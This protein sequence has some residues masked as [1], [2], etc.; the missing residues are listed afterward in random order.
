MPSHLKMFI[1]TIG[2]AAILALNSC[3]LGSSAPSA[4]EEQLPI[5]DPQIVA[6]LRE[7][8]QPFLTTKP[9]SGFDDLTNLKN[10]V[11]PAHLVALGEATRGTREFFEMKHRILQYLVTQMGFTV[12][13]MESNWPETN[14]I[15]DYVQTG[16]GDPASLIKGIHSSFLN[17][18][19]VLDMVR[20]VR[21]YNQSAANGPKVG[22]YGIDILYPRMAMDNVVAYLQRI[23]V[24]ASRTADSL[25]AIFRPYQDNPQSFVNAPDSVKS[26]SAWN[27]QVVYEHVLE[28]QSNYEAIT[29]AA[30]YAMALQTARVVVESE[31]FYLDPGHA[32]TRD[33]FMAENT[34]W[35]LRQAGP[36]AKM[37]VW[38]H[39]LHVRNAG[40]GTMGGRLRSTH[41][42]DIVLCGFDFYKGA[43]N[44]E[45]YVGNVFNGLGRQ[46][47]D[48]PPSDSYEY[49]FRASTIPR[50]IL[51]MREI[52]SAGWIAGPRRTRQILEQYDPAL[53]ESY[54]YTCPLSSW[55]DVIIY[56]QDTNTS[57][58]LF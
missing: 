33:G 56:L 31:S 32:P 57:T 35:L 53:T 29:S 49:A 13:A 5:M 9:G 37:V 20:W 44:A 55:F 11:G 43:F 12:F 38:A 7:N 2:T 34:E 22:F 25:Y 15:N 4:P 16:V 3:D 50:F 23:D 19:E 14:L 52:G 24:S 21:Q 54:Y 36:G 10:L 8:A 46:D 58:L 27:L 17:T 26:L 28:N 42:N 39:N 40:M 1:G 48:T 51:D 47:S 41:G 18:Q 30:Q 45:R 6:W